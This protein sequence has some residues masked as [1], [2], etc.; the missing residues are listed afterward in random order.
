LLVQGGAALV[1]PA[2]E[3]AD[4]QPADGERIDAP[5]E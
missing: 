3:P 4:N 5:S 2:A 1:G